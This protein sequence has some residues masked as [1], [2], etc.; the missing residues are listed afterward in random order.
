MDHLSLVEVEEASLCH[1][2]E[3]WVV[4]EEEVGVGMWVRPRW[5]GEGGQS[6]CPRREV[7]LVPE[8]VEEEQGHLQLQEEG[9]VGGDLWVR[10]SRVAVGTSSL[11]PE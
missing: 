7:H 4:G 9:E 8:E 6:P 10:S 1:L 2:M 3:R 5:V 11:W